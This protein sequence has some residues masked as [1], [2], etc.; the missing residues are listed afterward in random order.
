MPF[1]PFLSLPPIGQ[2]ACII[3]R[4]NISMLPP[5]KRGEVSPTSPYCWL[6]EW[7]IETS[8]GAQRPLMLASLLTRH[9]VA[10]VGG[11]TIESM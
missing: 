6:L 10:I 4:V 7:C 8:M 5:E 2:K 9:A 1:V 11:F 3:K